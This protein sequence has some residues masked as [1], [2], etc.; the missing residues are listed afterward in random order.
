MYTLGFIKAYLHFQMLTKVAG[1]S[2]CTK[3]ITKVRNWQVAK[4][5]FVP[6][7]L[8]KNFYFTITPLQ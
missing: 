6:I 2:A 5:Q 4:L 3:G 7:L 8:V 1:S